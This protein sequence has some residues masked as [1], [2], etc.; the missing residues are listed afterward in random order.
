[1]D[2]EAFGIFYERFFPRVWAYAVSRIGRQP[3]EDAVAETFAV[4]WRRRAD[5]PADPLPWLLA[6]ARNVIR[7]AGRA[8]A[9]QRM[10]MAELQ[11]WLL[12]GGACG[13]EVAEGVV[14][15]AQVLA[16]LASLSEADQEL[17]VL[18]A[19]HGLT[20]RQAAIA[21]GCSRPA[22]FVRLHRARRRLELAIRAQSAGWL[23]PAAVPARTP[24]PEE[25]SR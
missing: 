16:A 8:E 13:D 7:E 4:A 9:R 21:L 1:M 25:V 20:P 11:S 14:N 22:F 5:I 10:L 19:W 12:P 23:A 24:L 3:A 2:Q 18:V 15:R 6:V 17:L